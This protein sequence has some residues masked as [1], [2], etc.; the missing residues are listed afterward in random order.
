MRTCLLLLLF[1]SYQV[2]ISQSNDDILMAN[3]DENT[4]IKNTDIEE[5]LSFKTDLKEKYNGKDFVYIDDL[6]TKE[7]VKPEISSPPNMGILALFV[8]FMSYIF[9][10]LL[11]IIVV[12]IILKILLG[13]DMRFWSLKNSSKKTAEQLMYEDEDIHE[14]DF[15]KLLKQAIGNKDYRLATRYYYLSIL[16]KLSDIKT[17]E[18]HK[19]KT[20]TEYVFEIEDKDLRNQ[21]SEVSYIYS[22][23]WYGEFPINS[24][25]FQ[26]I[27]KKYKTLFNSIS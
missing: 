20:N 19:D 4:Y 15:N 16:Q 25:N 18:Y 17:I 3:G 9:P 13:S 1:L 7:P 12:L 24:N 22:Y 23:V 26:T 21:F 8:N 2:G 6:K 11:G 10:Y 14:A 5:K 27:E